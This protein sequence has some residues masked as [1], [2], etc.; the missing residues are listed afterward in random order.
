MTTT[1][2][3]NTSN[4]RRT[5][6]TLFQTLKNSIEAAPDNANPWTYGNSFD[7]MLD[8]MMLTQKTGDS[9]IRK[10]ATVLAQNGDWYDD[11]CWPAIA[12]LKACDPLYESVFAGYRDKF[13]NIVLNNWRLIYSGSNDHSSI[14]SFGTQNVGNHISAS[15]YDSVQPRFSGGAWQCDINREGNG[16]SQD[17]T[18]PYNKKPKLSGPVLGPFQDTVINDL[19]LIYAT[20]LSAMKASDFPNSNPVNVEI[21]INQANTARSEVHSFLMNWCN[22]GRSSDKVDRNDSLLIFPS[23]AAF[24]NNNYSG[25][26][27]VRERVGT[28]AKVG[29]SY[30]IPNAY[31]PSRA[32]TGDQGLMLGGLVDHSDPISQDIA[33]GILRGV[34]ANLYQYYNNQYYVLNSTSLNGWNENNSYPYY[35]GC[36]TCYNAGGGGIFMRNLLYALLT[37]N[38]TITALIQQQEYMAFVGNLVHTAANLMESE[39]PNGGS[40]SDFVALD[41]LATLNVAIYFEEVL[42]NPLPQPLL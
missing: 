6:E 11:W 9:V 8:Y 14:H 2:D 40:N 31:A 29:T 17:P 19:L 42:N 20:R 24:R 41:R 10:A 13:E 25:G 7:S 16:I 28:Y 37:N 34:K 5:A 4:Y 33:A 3:V 32:W 15:Y 22:M 35:L 26:V 30:P 12:A 1:N 18:I 23:E 21:A 36:P 38:P 27:I 39:D